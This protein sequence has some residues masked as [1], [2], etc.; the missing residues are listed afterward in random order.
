MKFLNQITT[1]I[2]TVF[3]IFSNLLLDSTWKMQQKYSIS[4]LPIFNIE[5]GIEAET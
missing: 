4:S 5:G 1:N 2:E 3:K